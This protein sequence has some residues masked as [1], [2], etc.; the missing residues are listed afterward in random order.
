MTFN[1]AGF[2][3]AVSHALITRIT[4]VIGE[5]PDAPW[6][7]AALDHIYRD[8]DVI[9]LPQLGINHTPDD[10]TRWSPP[11]WNRRWRGAGPMPDHHADPSIL[12]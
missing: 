2:Q 8:S 9:T 6:Y 12:P 4:S 10:D 3:Q 11:D 7:A 1:W 5:Q